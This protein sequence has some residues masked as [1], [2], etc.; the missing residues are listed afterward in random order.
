MIT[1][2]LPPGVT[3]RQLRYW[4]NQGYLPGT[5][6]SGG[7]KNPADIWTDEQWR[8]LALMGHLRLAG[9]E[10][11]Q[12]GEIAVAAVTQPDVGDGVVIQKVYPGV[13]ILVD[14]KE[15]LGA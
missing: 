14:F 1:M 15:A 9:I 2:K 8:M 4:V 11:R 5:L 10:A 7:R 6:T 3:Y 13:T 12:A